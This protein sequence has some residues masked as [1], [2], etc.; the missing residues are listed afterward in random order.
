MSQDIVLMAIQGVCNAAFQEGLPNQ[1]LRYLLPSLFDPCADHIQ[2]DSPLSATSCQCLLPR[3]HWFLV[4]PS[5]AIFLK[6]GGWCHLP[7]L[8]FDMSLIDRIQSEWS[9]QRDCLGSAHENLPWIIKLHICFIRRLALG[10]LVGEESLTSQLCMELGLE[11]GWCEF[12]GEFQLGAGAVLRRPPLFFSHY[13]QVN[14][15]W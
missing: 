4:L 5:H 15:E 3:K 11:A 10:N 14:A 7:D 1:L 8:L 12:W 13:A 9:S 6:K 2:L